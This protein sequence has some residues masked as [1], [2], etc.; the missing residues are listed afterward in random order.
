MA[1]II[2]ERFI[3]EKPKEWVGCSMY[4]MTAL[5][6]NDNWNEIVWRCHAYG[7]TEFSIGSCILRKYMNKRK[8]SGSSFHQ[9]L[10]SYRPNH[11]SLTIHSG[12]HGLGQWVTKIISSFTRFLMAFFV[13]NLNI[14]HGFPICQPRSSSQVFKKTHQGPRASILFLLHILWPRSLLHVFWPD[15]DPLIF[16]LLLLLFLSFFPSF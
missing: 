8:P 15:R 12:S 13:G 14:H 9:K 7:G 1:L 5:V 2:N 16:Y 10:L 4:L 6:E 11:F 3:L